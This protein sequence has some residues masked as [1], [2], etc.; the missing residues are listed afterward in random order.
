MR[1][2]E[3]V[4]CGRVSLLTNCFVADVLQELLVEGSVALGA[5][6]GH[7]RTHAGRY[8]GCELPGPTIA[9]RKFYKIIG[10]VRAGLRQPRALF[11][12]VF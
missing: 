2:H 11:F 6:Y 8:I 1:S 4:K 9:A 12:S 10:G 3:A 7:L 5:C